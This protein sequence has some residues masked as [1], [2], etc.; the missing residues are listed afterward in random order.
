MAGS[1]GAACHGN[2]FPR[3]NRPD[4]RDPRH[5]HDRPQAEFHRAQEG[6][7]PRP[8]GSVELVPGKFGKAC[9]FTFAANAADGFFEADVQA[10][11]EWDKAAGI[12]FWVKGD[13]SQSWGGIR[14]IDRRD[15]ARLYSFCFP[16]DSTE[17]RKITVAW[18]DLIPERALSKFIDPAGG[19][20]PSRFGYICFGKE[21]HWDDFPA[22]SFA[23]DQI[24]LEPEIPA[25]KTD[26]TP[27]RSGTPRFLAKLKAGQPVTMVTMADSLSDP[28][29]WANKP[30]RGAADPRPFL[31]SAQV[32]EKLQAVRRPVRLVNR[33]PQSG[34][35]VLRGI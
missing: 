6:E 7:P 4:D 8:C 1:S 23:I 25:D 13:G 15:Y 10:T 22:C 21:K 29:H 30:A 17:W 16:I 9:R 28:R 24:A 14:L 32:V 27:A 33:T 20:A 35:T 18:A 26:Y 2:G 34:R 31:W 5:G 19:Y 12:S 3:P 11:P